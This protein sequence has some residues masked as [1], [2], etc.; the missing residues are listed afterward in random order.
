MEI[1]EILWRLHTRE[2]YLEDACELL[3]IQ[4]MRLS[5][6][7][8]ASIEAILAEKKQGQQKDAMD[9]GI[10]V[11]TEAVPVQ[12][13]VQ[14][15]TITPVPVQETVQ[16]EIPVQEEMIIPEIPVQAIVPEIQESAEI[17]EPIRQDPFYEISEEAAKMIDAAILEQNIPVIITKDFQWAFE[18]ATLLLGDAELVNIPEDDLLDIDG[19]I[20]IIAP[21]KINEIQQDYYAMLL[22]PKFED[23]T[24]ILEKDCIEIIGDE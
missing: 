1:K 20:N 10:L 16:E 14:E 2:M 13:T 9:D 8:R 6:L 11:S 18:L 22:K 7:Y 5:K 19:P 23:N 21:D 17:D 4:P 12:E 15:E 3:N 24:V